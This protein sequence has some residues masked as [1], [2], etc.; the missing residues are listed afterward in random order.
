MVEHVCQ[1]GDEAD[2]V[3]ILDNYDDLEPEDYSAFAISALAYACPE[4]AGQ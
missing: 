2:G 4:E 1:F 3:R